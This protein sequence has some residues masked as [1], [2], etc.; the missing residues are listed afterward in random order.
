MSSRSTNGSGIGVRV[1]EDPSPR[2]AL[3]LPAPEVV[4]SLAE[5]FQLTHLL[6]RYSERPIWALFMFINGFVTISL[7]AGV[8]MVS[9]TPFVFSSLGP[10]AF[11][12][13]REGGG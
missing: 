6:T 2:R 7:L 1:A 4:H 10:T 13:E 5:R 9:P 8:A 11:L 12:F 3:V